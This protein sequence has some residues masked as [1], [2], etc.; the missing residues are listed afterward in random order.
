M[1]LQSPQAIE[2]RMLYQSGLS[3][4]MGD[5]VEEYARPEYVFLV[6]K[7]V[8]NKDVALGVDCVGARLRA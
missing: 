4:I 8:P 3:V 5:E 6:S 2:G 7:V 1:S